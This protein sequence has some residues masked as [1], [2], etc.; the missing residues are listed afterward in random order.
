MLWP[1]QK[2]PFRYRSKLEWMLSE[3]IPMPFSAIQDR[4][5]YDE[6]VNQYGELRRYLFEQHLKT[7]TPDQQR[8]IKNG[9]HPSQSHAL[10]EAA[11]AH[12]QALN[13]KLKNLQFVTKV[14]VGTYHGNRN[15]LDVFVNG[16]DSLDPRL[17]EIPDFFEGF[18]VLVLN[19]ANKFE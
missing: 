16:I 13:E 14:S 11:F 12:A 9:D 8:L 1:F 18:E 3:K 5:R 17:L 7:L 15:V 19:R 6:V 2:K 10:A 4:K